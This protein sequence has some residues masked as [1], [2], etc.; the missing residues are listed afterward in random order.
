MNTM[1]TVRL[2]PPANVPAKRTRQTNAFSTARDDKTAMRPFAKLL[3]TLV[4]T[5]MLHITILTSIKCSLIGALAIHRYRNTR[6][7][8]IIIIIIIT[9]TT[10]TMWSKNF[11]GRPSCLP[12]LYCEGTIWYLRRGNWAW[13][14]VLTAPGCLASV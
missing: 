1:R 4:V 6:I 7:S 14:P 11:D 10:T 2:P 12:F 8:L 13:Y 5:V 9:T 3:W